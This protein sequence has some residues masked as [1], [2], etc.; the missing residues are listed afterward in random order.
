MLKI[1]FTRCLSVKKQKS[2]QQCKC[3]Y[4][5]NSLFCG[6]HI[7]MKTK[8]CVDYFFYNKNA[9]KIQ[10]IFRGYN[11][12]RRSKCINKI[13]CITLTNIYNISPI[14]L[15]IYYQSNISKYYAFN[16]KFLNEI[17]NSNST[18]NP[19]TNYNFNQKDIMNIKKNIYNINKLGYNIK[20]KEDKLT[21]IQYINSYTVETF[22]KIDLLGNYTNHAWFLNLNLRKLKKLYYYSCDIFYNQVNLSYTD[23]IKYVKN[24]KVFMMKRY[25]LRKIKNINKMRHIILDEYNKFLDYDISTKSDKQ[26]AVLWLLSALINVSV[27]ARISLSHLS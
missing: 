18:K 24:G 25:S 9:I 27:P 2:T 6:R 7:K 5:N 20:I 10:K 13:D 17:I 23:R 1:D 4:K 15:Y 22:H 3:K 14:Y 11:I 16:I 19:Y 8:T 12:Y 26:T 21:D